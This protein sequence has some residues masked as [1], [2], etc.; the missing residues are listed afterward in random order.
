MVCY[1]DVGCF[2]DEGP[3][4]YL[5]MLPS[6]PEEIAT[7]FLLYST[8][9]TRNRDRDVPHFMT[10]NN[11]TSVAGAPFNAS[12]PTKVMIHGFGSSCTR[13]WAKEMREALIRV[14]S[15]AFISLF[16]RKFPIA[17]TSSQSLFTISN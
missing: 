16:L 4:D 2:R 11:A 3:F 1:A 8:A 9:S 17:M 5:D 15:F 6:P 7:R 12:L 13:V 14:V 10:Y